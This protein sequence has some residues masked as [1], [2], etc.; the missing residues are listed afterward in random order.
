MKMPIAFSNESLVKS[1]EENLKE[2]YTYIEAAV[3]ASTR[4]REEVRIVK[5][6]VLR[7][8]QRMP[9]KSSSLDTFSVPLN[10]FSVNSTHLVA[11]H[12]FSYFRKISYVGGPQ[13]VH[14]PKRNR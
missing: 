11:V 5:L 12:A 10:P 2:A 1:C 13:K 14:V 7:I 4:E 9:G 3:A 6:E 8:C